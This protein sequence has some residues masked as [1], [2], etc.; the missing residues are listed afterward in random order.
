MCSKLC[1]FARLVAVIGRLQDVVHV[2]LRRRWNLVCQLSSALVA[3]ARRPVALAASSFTGTH[4]A[5]PATESHQAV[6]WFMCINRFYRLA[7]D[8]DSTPPPTAKQTKHDDPVIWINPSLRLRTGSLP[9]VNHVF[10]IRKIS[11]KKFR[12]NP[13]TTFQL[14]HWDTNKRKN[15]RIDLQPYVD[16]NSTFFHQ[17]VLKLVRLHWVAMYKFKLRDFVHI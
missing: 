7:H 14:S 16:K 9:K 1:A 13:P 15:E 4:H 8:I 6:A 2:R 17:N 10:A 12:R 5:R 11:A 3:A